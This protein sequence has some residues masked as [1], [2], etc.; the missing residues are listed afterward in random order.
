MRL[1]RV[2]AG[3]F[4]AVATALVSPHADAAEYEVFVDVDDEEELY[5][6]Q[7]TD[8][9]SDETFQTLVE[10][11]RRGV[12]LNEASREELYQ[13]PNLTYEDVD[14]ILAYRQEVGFIPDPASLVIAGVVTER[15][16]A[17]IA[18]FLVV[19]EP[20][21]ALAAT[22]GFV[23]A[24]TQYAPSDGS[25]APSAALQ[26]R[27]TTAR[28]LTLGG[29]MIHS[30][31]RVGDVRWDPTRE[32]L[33]ATEPTS[34]V[35]APKFFAQWDPGP[36]GVIAGTYRI[37]F[38]QRLVFDNSGRYSPNGFFLDDAVFRG[39]QM[40]RICRESTG[41]L[42]ASPC[43][44][45]AGSEYVTPDFSWREG[46]R[47]VAIGFRHAELPVGW[48]QGY[49]WASYQNKDIYQYEI[50]DR[51]FCEDPRNDDDPR[52]SAPPVY[53]RNEDD[54]LAPQAAH[55]FQTLPNMYDEALGGANLTW[56]H[57]RR[58]HVGVTGY[59]AVPRW[60]VQGADLDFQ[61]WS[62]TPTG[63]PY[64][65][66]GADAAWGRRWADVFVEVARSFDSTE[67]NEYGPGGGDWGAIVRQTST[68]DSHELELAARW[69]GAGFANPYARSIAGPDEYEGNRARDEAGLR[70][71]YNGLI[72]DRLSLRALVDVWAQ[73]REGIP[74]FNSYLRSDVLVVD[75]F[76]PGFWFGY[77]NRDLR[78]FDRQGCYEVS[79]EEDENGETIPCSGERF[80]MTPRLSFLPHRR[81]KITAQYQHELLDDP[82]YDGSFRQDAS[83][84][85]IV[86]TNPWRTLRFRLRSRYRFEDI[87]DNTHLEQSVWTYLEAS[88]RFARVLT[89]RL[90]YDLVVW[91]D[92]RASTMD[93][94]PSPEHWLRLQLEARF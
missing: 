67:A 72:A 89:T 38:G 90:R 10:L 57:Q 4:G 94:S 49:A 54:P 46:L 37:G 65:A 93:R 13:L 86:N 26:A 66:V 47:G 16:V 91:L 69:Y 33:S 68:W 19:R 51:N 77:Q 78:T 61:E 25:L 76:T 42:D 70:T 5:D 7:V 55:S 87:Q 84:A 3:I 8:Q 71:R 27:V 88:Y 1:L 45:A 85:L 64:G 39:T 28:Y 92:D 73:P 36:W 12:D 2:G 52:C 21:R 44:G 9:I 83:A 22:N 63:G 40:S 17:S 50:T 14:A 29:A 74:K 56:F 32:A 18:A 41:E 62:A 31:L 82:N 30:R 6:L 20:G 81:V 23:R 80:V 53:V 15:K 24:Q 75:W 60:R 48:M 59:G 58:T 79:V 35:H 11:M 43:A 34:R